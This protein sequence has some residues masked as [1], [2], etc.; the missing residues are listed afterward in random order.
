MFDLSHLLAREFARRQRDGAD[1]FR[2]P[3][4][5]CV[6]QRRAPNPPVSASWPGGDG[7]ADSPRPWPR[8]GGAG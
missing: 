8:R 7:A 6:S 5:A 4:P 3:D 2:L 1:I